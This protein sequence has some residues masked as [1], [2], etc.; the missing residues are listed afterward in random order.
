MDKRGRIMFAY[1][2]SDVNE[3]LG[4][5]AN[6]LLMDKE[7]KSIDFSCILGLG[8]DLD[9]NFHTKSFIYHADGKQKI[10]FID[11]EITEL[12]VE[13]TSKVFISEN[14][15]SFIITE[16]FRNVTFDKSGLYQIK[17]YLYGGMLEDKNSIDEI[18]DEKDVCFYVEEF[19]EEYSYDE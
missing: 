1:V 5:P 17:I 18:I 10:D 15:A 16:R 2:S 14:N 3:T 7:S 19:R 9:L 8:V 13:N 12:N 4:E 11:D 6:Y